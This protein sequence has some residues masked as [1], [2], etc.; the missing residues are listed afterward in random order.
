MTRAPA[1]AS[2]SSTAPARWGPR[3]ATASS[4]TA[5]PS[6]T[7]EPGSTSASTTPASRT[8][9]PGGTPRSMATGGAHPRPPSAVSPARR[10]A[11]RSA[12]CR[13][14][15]HPAFSKGRPA[16]AM[17]ERGAIASMDTG[18]ILA[19]ARGATL[20][21]HEGTP[22]PTPWAKSDRT[23]RGGRRELRR[24]GRGWSVRH[25]ARNRA[26]SSPFG[27][28]HRGG[29]GPPNTGFA[30]GPAPSDRRA[31]RLSRWVNVIGPR[32]EEGPH[33]DHCPQG[34]SGGRVHT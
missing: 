18:V 19:A 17:R 12:S 5:R 30:R 4:A 15:A 21:P 23:T 7:S 22:E 3:S 24:P 9:R 31:P 27:E 29:F 32:P 25:E 34:R 2:A 28:R 33:E 1:A 20:D 11:L 16:A 6:A 10:S 8:T 14:P 26:V 13:H